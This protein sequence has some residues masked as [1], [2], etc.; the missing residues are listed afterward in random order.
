MTALSAAHTGD[1]LQ[2]ELAAAVKAVESAVLDLQN[3]VGTD[4]TADLAKVAGVTNGTVAA[5]KAIVVDANKH[6]DVANVTTL[7]IGASGSEIAVTS[8]PTELNLLHSIVAG[9]VAAGKALVASAGSALS[10]LLN[11]TF[12][13][14]TAT[15]AP[16]NL[17]A[18]TNLTTPVA[19]AVEFDGTAFYA[20]AVANSRQQID[21]EQYAIATSDSATYNNTGLDTASAAPVF[22]AA[23]GGSANGAITLVAGKT[24]AFEA[25]YILTNTGTTSHTW[26]VLFGGAATFT[27]IMYSI[28]GLS[29]ASS[30]PASGGLSGYANV[31]TAVVSTPASTSATENV[32]I[33]LNGVFVVNAG[34]TV[35]PQMIASA[36]PG[37]SGTPGVVVKKGSYFRIWEMAGTGTLGNWS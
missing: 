20:T 24:Y 9:T 25:N 33:Q 7:A 30:A 15:V 28:F 23:M 36:R 17:A 34:G 13:A 6:F 21:A 27:S 8:T 16:I 26:A 37:A 1:L 35:I 19:G 31:A 5:S 14:G 2:T 22:T 12:G 11:L 3:T 29:A 10:G 18:G 32:T 4:V